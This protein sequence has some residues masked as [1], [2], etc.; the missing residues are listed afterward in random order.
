MPQLLVSRNPSDGSIVGE[1]VITPPAGVAATVAAARVAQPSWG[2]LTPA[3]R[4]ERIRPAGAILAARADDIGRLVTAEM[5]KPLREAVG[6]VKATAAMD[7]DL[8]AMAEALADEVSEDDTTR[9]VVH[10]D[11][12]GVAAA[13]T[14][15]NFPVMMPH[16]MVL[17][18]LMAGNAV[19]LKPSEETPLCAQAYADAL[20]EVLPE[21]VLAVVQGADAQGKE[22]VGSAIDLIAFTGSRETGLAIM[23]AAARDLKR[24]VLELGGKDPLLV[25]ADADVEAAARFAARNCFRNAGQVCVSTE[26]IYVDEQVADRFLSTLLDESAKLVVGDGMDERSRV[27]PLV[28]ERQRD[29]VLLQI[30]DARA[31]GAKVLLG[32]GPA[33]GNF[34]DPTVLV[35][36]TPDMAIARDET[37]GPVACVTRVAS[38]DEAVR[39]ANDSP[40]GLGAVVFGAADHAQAIARCLNAGMI[41]VNRGVGGAGTPWVGARQSGYGF[42]G[43]RDGHRQFAQTRVVST[44][45]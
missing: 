29:H 37:F 23:A 32:G 27:G 33:R 44:P 25:L 40:F 38:D 12:F 30:A 15:W 4:A 17:P 5:G 2:A 41:G 10:H 1:V 8:D 11:P 19:V 13:I 16:W 7:E 18:G 6:E 39:L 14:P 35:D 21:G 42:H 22:L 24:V 45:K 3:Q 34:I 26:R 43:S 20:R 31:R 28:N 9:S 36:V